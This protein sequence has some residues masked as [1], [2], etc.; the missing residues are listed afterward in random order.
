MH[1]KLAGAALLA[2]MSGVVSYIFLQQGIDMTFDSAVP[3]AIRGFGVFTI[4]Y[5]ILNLIFLFSAW[6]FIDYRIERA[7]R[8]C[9]LGFFLL[10][11]LSALEEGINSI[12][13]VG[14]FLAFLM[15]FVNWLAV[16]RAIDAQK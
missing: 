9:A 10:T 14:I 6:H 16:W 1:A 2:M 15:L 3:L 12:E 4:L 8:Y 11:I 13:E 5:S 7:A